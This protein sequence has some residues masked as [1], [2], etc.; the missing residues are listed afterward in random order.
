MFSDGIKVPSIQFVEHVLYSSQSLCALV[1]DIRKCF[2][3]KEG[4][5]YV[6]V[7]LSCGS[8]LGLS[9]HKHNFPT[10]KRRPLLLI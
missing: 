7:T 4:C 9:E 6:G 1:E 3:W 8:L 10:S 2:F 5:W